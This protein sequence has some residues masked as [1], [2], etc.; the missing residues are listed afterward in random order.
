MDTWLSK[1]LGRTWWALH[2]SPVTEQLVSFTASVS[3][4]GRS[5]MSWEAC[6]SKQASLFSSIWNSEQKLDYNRRY[7]LP[8]IVS[9]V[10]KYGV[11][12]VLPLALLPQCLTP[13]ES[14]KRK[15]WGWG[16]QQI[17]K[18]WEPWP[19]HFFLFSS[20]PLMKQWGFQQEQNLKHHKVEGRT[21]K[22]INLCTTAFLV[23][24]ETH[25]L[26]IPGLGWGGPSGFQRKGSSIWKAQVFFNSSWKY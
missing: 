23:L 13:R 2:L 21:A 19:L 22:C 3:S 18:P 14:W 8:V 11:F 24:W 25:M 17:W 16:I 4:S 12:S 20:F 7:K 6:P 15:G 10:V 9:E 26:C 5:T 1:P